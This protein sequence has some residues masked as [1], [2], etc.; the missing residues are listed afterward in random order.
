MME[1]HQLT[2]TDIGYYLPHQANTRIVER[3]ASSIGF[4]KEQLISNIKHVGNTGSA[5]MLIAL[6]HFLKSKS[7]KKGTRI[8]M[9]ACGAGLSKGT[10]LLEAVHD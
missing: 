9:N 5:S 7:L 1:R 4:S 8:L 2:P 3:A 6:D 10:A